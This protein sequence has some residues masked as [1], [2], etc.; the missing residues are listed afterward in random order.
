MSTAEA[1]ALNGSSVRYNA[2]KLDTDQVVDIRRKYRKDA[3]IIDLADEYGVT[4]QSIW[5]IV[6]YKVYQNLG[7]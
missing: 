7:W 3:R 4:K 2:P 6:H 5:A 1:V